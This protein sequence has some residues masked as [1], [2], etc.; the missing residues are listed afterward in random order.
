[1]P[2][3]IDE[4]SATIMASDLIYL[5]A[6]EEGVILTEYFALTS[7][8]NFFRSID[9]LSKMKK[10]LAFTASASYLTMPF[11]YIMAYS[12]VPAVNIS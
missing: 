1:M 11:L 12:M 3:I 8:C 10:S 6:V 5:R 2:L 4:V 9:G 7:V